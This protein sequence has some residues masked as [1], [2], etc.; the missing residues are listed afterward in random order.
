MYQRVKDATAAEFVAVA[1]RV[2]I[3]PGAEDSGGELASAPAAQYVPEFA[4]A[5]VALEPGE[6]SQPVHTQFGWH[7]IYLVDK[8]VQPFEEAK[9]GL[10]EPRRRRRVHGVAR[11]I[12]RSSWAS[13]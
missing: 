1:R 9:A 7:V 4:N 6:I 5:V 2:S 12:A 13:R 3:E 10:L 8:E 11:R